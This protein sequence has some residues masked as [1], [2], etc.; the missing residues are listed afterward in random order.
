MSAPHTADLV[1]NIVEERLLGNIDGVSITA[2]VVSGGRAGSK[3]KG[4]VNPF[5]ANNPYAT[6][7]KQSDKTPGGPLILG[8]YTLRTHEKKPNY[9]RLIPSTGNYMR[10]RSGF[11][12][13]GRGQR[14]S[15]GCIV[16]TDFPVVQKIYDLVRAREKNKHP[17]P[18]LAVVAIGDLDFIDRRLRQL[19]H[20]A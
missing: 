18:T 14:G 8:L 19:A 16:P 3:K 12:I 4:V 11:L 7:V 9:I 2:H 13:H 5:L 1:Y 10:G 17:P 15:D 20:T 6:G